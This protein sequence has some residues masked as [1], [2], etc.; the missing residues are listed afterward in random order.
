MNTTSKNGQ[1]LIQN[2][3]ENYIMSIEETVSLIETA[4][5]NTPIIVDFDETLLLSNS[6]Q[7]YL[8][9]LYPRVFG[10]AL[11]AL[12][13]YVQPWNWLPRKFHG[14]VSRDWLRVVIATILF[15]WTP[16]IWQWRAKQLAR[17]YQNAKLIEAITKTKGRI[18]IATLGFDSIVRPLIKHLPLPISGLITCRFWQ[19]VVDRS[20]GK[21]VLVESR[22]GTKA[23]ANAIAVTD[24]S[25]D[26]PLLS[27]VAKPCLIIWP[28]TKSV[29]ML[30]D[31]YV[32]FL[33][34]ERIK[35]TSQRHFF[36]QILTDDLLILILALSWL[37]DRPVLHA[38]GIGI[39]LLSFYCIYEVGYWK[40]DRIAEQFEKKPCLS[41]AYH[42]YQFKMPLI[43]PWIWASSLAIIGL[44]LLELSE[45]QA[46]SAGAVWELMTS[47]LTPGQLPLVSW[48]ELLVLVRVIFWAFNHVNKLTRIWLYPLLQAAKYF[49]FLC[50]TTTNSIGAMLFVSQVISR[51]LPYL[52]YRWQQEG[53]SFPRNFPD[54]LSRLLLFGLLLG[55]LF[56]GERHLSIMMNWQVLA[57]MVLFFLR[58]IKDIWR[59]IRQM[60]PISQVK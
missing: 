55:A 25:N 30:A 26:F 44:L 11:L 52:I 24:S 37:S 16:I 41:A 21:H 31:V 3:C 51:S 27:L 40:N 14:E 48:L 36:K 58:A 56:I 7:E 1:A 39:L 6:T 47:V 10:V 60:K 12:L 22:L 20:V 59:V 9:A 19:G 2:N 38:L 5:Y 23:V 8:N 33:Y 4:S 45:A 34:S 46:D 57:I 42:R 29:S 28:K 15:P 32:P 50:I 53:T 18:I 13:N 49:G 54:R 17:L 35:R 43:Q